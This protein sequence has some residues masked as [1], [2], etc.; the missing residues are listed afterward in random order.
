MT[1]LLGTL[2]PHDWLALTGTVVALVITTSEACRR[3]ARF[4]KQLSDVLAKLSDL[5]YS[6]TRVRLTEE[7]THRPDR[8]IG[9]LNDQRRYLVRQAAFLADK[10]EAEVS[11]YELLMIA[12]AF[13]SAD[14]RWQTERYFRSRGS[15][16]RSR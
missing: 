9:P 7:E 16:R 8:S 10:L 13:D 2:G 6:I 11:T 3:E 15:E 14:D 1:N 5:N 4:A 12:S